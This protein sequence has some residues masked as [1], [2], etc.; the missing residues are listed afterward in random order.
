MAVVYN[1]DRS[2]SFFGEMTTRKLDFSLGHIMTMKK[3]EADRW[4]IRLEGF[5]FTQMNE[6][7]FEVYCFLWSS[8]GYHCSLFAAISKPNSGLLIDRTTWKLLLLYSVSVS[9]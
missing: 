4:M 8:A 6:G 9:L 7:S 2:C 1:F 5:S 3:K